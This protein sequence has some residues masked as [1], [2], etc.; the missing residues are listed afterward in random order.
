MSY[1]DK[2]CAD[3]GGE[4]KMIKLIDQVMTQHEEMV[5]TVPDAQRSFWNSKFP[6]AGS[7]EA[8][9]CQSCGWIKLY[10]RSKLN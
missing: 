2:P 9:M 3:C 1:E 6:V 7:V 8:T 10:G 4:M 5:Y